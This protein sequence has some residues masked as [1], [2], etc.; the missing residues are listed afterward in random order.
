MCI[1]GAILDRGGAVDTAPSIKSVTVFLNSQNLDR[2]I[3]QHYKIRICISFC[4][5]QQVLPKNANFSGNF[6]LGLCLQKA[7]LQKHQR[8][9]YHLFRS[10]LVQIHD[11]CQIYELLTKVITFK[12]CQIDGMLTKSLRG[13]KSLLR[14]FDVSLVL[15]SLAKFYN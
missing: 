9:N 13:Y 8:R 11:I 4:L 12:I 15:N 3:R 1:F 5:C 14:H 2:S 10:S 7:S 6:L